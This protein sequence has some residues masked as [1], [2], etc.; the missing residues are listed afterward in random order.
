VINLKTGER[1]REATKTMTRGGFL[2]GIL[3]S[4]IAPSI[5]LATI[6]DAGSANGGVGRGMMRG[7]GAR[8]AAVFGGGLSALDYIG[9]KEAKSGQS[10]P[11]LAL[12]DGIENAELGEHNEKATKWVDLT[13]NHDPLNLIT[14]SGAYFTDNSIKSNSA[15]EYGYATSA[16]ENCYFTSCEIC[17]KMSNIGNWW[18]AVCGGGSNPKAYAMSFSWDFSKVSRTTNSSSFSLKTVPEKGLKTTIYASY[19][20]AAQNGESLTKIGTMGNWAASSKITIGSSYNGIDG[21]RG[22]YNN[23]EIH[24]VRMYDRELTHDEISF[25]Y[26]IDRARFGV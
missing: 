18:T 25:N 9:A 6:A 1:F 23:H 14:K 19:Y 13:G 3:A 21:A 10:S 20:N 16:T 15:T 11:L 2:K 7:V 17:L 8:N 5:T 4:G 12:W 22:Y 26:T 24:C